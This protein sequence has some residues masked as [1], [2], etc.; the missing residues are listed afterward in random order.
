MGPITSDAIADLRFEMEWESEQATHREVYAAMDVNIWRDHFP[1]ELSRALMG[2]SPGETVVI[3]TGPGQLLAP[4]DPKAAFSIN[5]GQFNPAHAG[6]RAKPGVGRFYPR[7]ILRNVANVF[8]QNM[9]PFRL[10]EIRNGRMGVD[11][12]HP[13]SRKDLRLSCRVEQVG[14]KDH[15]RG[16]TSRDWLQTISAGPGMQARHQGVATDYFSEDPFHRENSAP[17][18]RFYE[19]PRFVAHIDAAASGAV[20]ELYGR[21][22][23]D[24][25]SVLDLMSS[26]VSHIPESLYLDRLT[27]LGLNRAELDANPRLTEVVVQDLNQDSTLPFSSE[28]FDAVICTVS[29]EYLTHPFLVFRE[30]ARVL[31]PEGIALVT[32]S[33]RWFPPKA[34]RIWKALHEYERMGLVMEYFLESGRFSDLETDSLRG[35]PRPETDKYYGQFFAAD[36]V[37]AVWGK[38]K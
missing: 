4:P 28:T 10:V 9:E 30:M 29:V 17:D 22:L 27:G 25:M 20:S 34:I 26:W 18:A 38:R 13:L 32:F 11:F 21:L 16:G 35:L 19:H 36:P 7:G 23:K 12:N 15:E 31:R 1:P 37:Y 14:G 24:G 6:L 5:R 33:N 8:P 2:K 3:E